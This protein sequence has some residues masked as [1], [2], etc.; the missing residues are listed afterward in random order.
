MMFDQKILHI[1]GKKALLVREQPGS[2]HRSIEYEVH[3]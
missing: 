2:R 3:Q 1:F